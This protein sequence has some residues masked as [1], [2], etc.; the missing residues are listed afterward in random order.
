MR[1]L[2]HDHGRLR[3]ANP[4]IRIRTSRTL[5]YNDIKRRNTGN[6]KFL[7]R[8]Y[9]F[10]ITPSGDPGRVNYG[11]RSAPHVP[12]NRPAEELLQSR[13]DVLSHAA[14]DQR[15]GAATGAG[16]AR[17][18]VR[19]FRQPD[20]ADHRRQDFRGVRRTDAGPAPA[21][22]GRDRGAGNQSARRTGD[23][24][25]RGH[26]HLR[27]AEGVFANTAGCFPRCSCRCCAATARAWWKR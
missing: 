7:S 6:S 15:A 3:L 14:G 8:R 21:R 1:C 20:L 18:P 9:A 24:G 27:A 11:F 19:A 5:C 16:I 4:I 10:S 26:L 25:Q 23:R 17:R 2:R 13:P 22:A 12:G